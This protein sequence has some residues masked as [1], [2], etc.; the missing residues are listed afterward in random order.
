MKNVL[1]G[2]SF[3]SFIFFLSSNIYAIVIKAATPKKKKDVILKPGGKS[4]NGKYH[5]IK[6]N[7]NAHSLKFLTSI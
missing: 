1:S 5:S 6:N 7:T 4:T 3:L 2:Y